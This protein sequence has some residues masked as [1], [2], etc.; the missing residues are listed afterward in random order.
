MGTRE[1][2]IKT[3]GNSVITTTIISPGQDH[4]S[5]EYLTRQ[6]LK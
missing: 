5:I 6:D 2:T 1:D 3:A 4:S